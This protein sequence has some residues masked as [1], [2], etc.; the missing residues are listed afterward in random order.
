[1]A[2]LILT[3]GNKLE[4]TKFHI[5]CNTE[6][7]LNEITL[8]QTYYNNSQEISEG[9]YIY[10][11]V[12]D[13]IV[14]K[15]IIKC[16][17][18]VIEA[19]VYEKEE[20]IEKYNDAIAAGNKAYLGKLTEESS[21]MMEF[22]LGNLLP[23][24]EVKVEITYVTQSEFMSE[25]NNYRV[26]I[27]HVLIP[28]Y[29]PSGSSITQEMS[30]S[31]L[32][33][34]G[35]VSIRTPN[36]LTSITSNVSNFDISVQNDYWKT[37]NFSILNHYDDLCIYYQYRASDDP[38]IVFQQDPRNQKYA[39][40]L[41]FTPQKNDT[42]SPVWEP[43]GEFIILLDRSGSME[44]GSIKLAREAVYLFIKSLPE[45]SY[46]N[47]VS[48][49][50][51]FNKL[52]QQSVRYEQDKI[53]F[54]CNTVKTFDADMGGTEIL[55]PIKSI[56]SEPNR[57]EYL[58]YVFILTDGEVGNAAEIINYIKNQKTPSQIS[59]IG[60]GAGVSTYLINEVA[61]VGHGSVHH[62][63]NSSE[64]KS[65]VIS[66]LKK[67]LLPGIS[68][69]EIANPHEFELVGHKNPFSSFYG[70]KISYSGILKQGSTPEKIS[71][72]Y[73][74]DASKND[75]LIDFSINYEGM[76]KSSAALVTAVKNYFNDC[77]K[78]EIIEK[79]K[80]YQ[81]LSKYTA[82][83]GVEKVKNPNLKNYN[84][85]EEEC[86][87]DSDE[88]ECEEDCGAEINE[89]LCECLCAQEDYE[90]NEEYE[91]L[92][93]EEVKNMASARAFD[94]SAREIDIYEEIK[95][96]LKSKSASKVEYVESLIGYQFADGHWEFSRELELLINYFLGNQE[97]RDKAAPSMT[98]L[99]VGILI[100]KCREHEEIWDLIVNKAKRWLKKNGV[101]ERSLHDLGY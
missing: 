13:S 87:E 14:S 46:F 11:V 89:A 29:S 59:T 91:S 6:W 27:P 33:W 82:F 74:D 81:V 56:L 42:D 23:Q 54:A 38:F 94:Y 10:P 48:F 58:R 99:V 60:I 8:H 22:H 66:S 93:I 9:S 97:I 18:S 84:S 16:G 95:P 43:K 90:L 35:T 98:L 49:G 2:S 57:S 21:D 52:F 101:Q 78:N 41:S 47:V 34:T 72:K 26:Y 83:L 15:L 37:L 3:N 5:E 80:N 73:T 63:L 39:F 25:T 71:V 61:K 28:R 55:E 69:I 19:L 88:D 85:D 17:E 24:S 62:I 50:S 4:L 77:E 92:G 75:H 53:E 65:G 67:S 68:N 30:V 86:E 40:H 7:V 20:A 79:S 45:D 32:N 70:S 100:E 76:L 44:G 1:M 64:I 51:S 12:S 36:I 31:T 96:E